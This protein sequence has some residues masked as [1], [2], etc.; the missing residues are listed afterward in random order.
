VQSRPTKP[1]NISI[2]LKNAS[3]ALSQ[4]SNNLISNRQPKS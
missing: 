4:L 3:V 2:F 1:A